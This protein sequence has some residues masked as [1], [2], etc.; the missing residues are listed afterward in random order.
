M[1]DIDFILKTVYNYI[2][3]SKIGSNSILIGAF[4]L[5]IN[6]NNESNNIRPITKDIDFSYF[7]N[8]LELAIDYINFILESITEFKVI[9]TK[10]KFRQETK[11]ASIKFKAIL[12]DGSEIRGLGLDIGQKNKYKNKIDINGIQRIEHALAIKI[13]LETKDESTRRTKDLV[14]IFK[15]L[16]VK[17]KK[18]ITKQYVLQILDSYDMTMLNPQVWLDK[19]TIYSHTQA[20]NKMEKSKQLGIYS[21][22]EVVLTTSKFLVGLINSNLADN[23]IFI[24]GKWVENNDKR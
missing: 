7:D 24:N 14:D 1:N 4:A 17:Y 18:G 20:L 19:E 12:K 16:T 3:K 9:I 22:R 8:D 11:T 21:A 5:K 15:I 2:R 23:S 13:V 10:T 6:M